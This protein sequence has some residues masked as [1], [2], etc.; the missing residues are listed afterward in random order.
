MGVVDSVLEEASLDVG[1]EDGSAS[2]DT[3][4]GEEFEIVVNTDVDLVMESEGDTAV[5]PILVGTSTLVEGLVV[6][7]IA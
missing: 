3:A 1:A 6:G 2:D 4:V 7:E 5:V